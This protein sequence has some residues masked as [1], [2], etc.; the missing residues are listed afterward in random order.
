MCG[1]WMRRCRC[2][3]RLSRSICRDTRADRDDIGMGRTVVVVAAVDNVAAVVLEIG[4]VVAAAAAVVW[5]IV[6]SM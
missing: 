4:V 6:R 2:C 3:H 1:R 5:G